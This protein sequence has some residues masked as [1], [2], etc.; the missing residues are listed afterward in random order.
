MTTVLWHEPSM[1]HFK[2][3]QRRT[4]LPGSEF[5]F[6]HAAQFALR[7][8][9]ACDG[10]NLFED[11][12]ADLLHGRA[13]QDG[14]GVDVHVVGHVVVERRIGGHFDRWGWFAAEYGAAAGG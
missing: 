13:V 6:T 4:D 12:V 2:K 10:Q 3:S 8:F 9:A 5:L 7:L 11:L 1:V 14:A